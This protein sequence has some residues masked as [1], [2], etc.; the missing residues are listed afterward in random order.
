VGLSTNSFLERAENESNAHLKSLLR[1]TEKD[2]WI[3]TNLYPKLTMF[4]HRAVSDW[5]KYLKGEHYDEDYHLATGFAGSE[6]TPAD[7]TEALP[8]YQAEFAAAKFSVKKLEAFIR[9]MAQLQQQGISVVLVRMPVTHALQQLEAQHAPALDAYW[10]YAEFHDQHTFN[11]WG[12]YTTYDG[13]H[14]NSRSSHSFSR[15]LSVYL[16]G[17]FLEDVRQIRIRK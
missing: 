13:S 16:T 10:Q 3:R 12:M 17:V 5:Y 8:L 9:C 7:T 6:K 1:L 14:L 2:L 15:D 4:D 11:G